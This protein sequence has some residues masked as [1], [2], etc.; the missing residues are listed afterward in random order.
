MSLLNEINQTAD[1]ILAEQQIIERAIDVLG[2]DRSV[3]ISTER[4]LEVFLRNMI[5]EGMAEDR[6]MLAKMQAGKGDNAARGRAHEKEW[7]RDLDKSGNEYDAKK[8]KTL[9]ANK[10]GLAKDQRDVAPAQGHFILLPGGKF[11]QIVMVDK[12]EAGEPMVMIQS[13]YLKKEIIVNAKRLEGPKD[14]NGKPTW[15]IRKA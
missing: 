6:A 4:E 10:L 8:A 3:V 9:G 1:D 13:K 15:M 14:V 7:I 12:N 11:G 2:F 5:L